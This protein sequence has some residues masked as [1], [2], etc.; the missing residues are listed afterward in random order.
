MKRAAVK[1]LL[2]NFIVCYD[3][4]NLIIISCVKKDPF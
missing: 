4:G 2:S 1:Y 3:V